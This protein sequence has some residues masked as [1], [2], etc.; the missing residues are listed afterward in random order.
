MVRPAL[1]RGRKLSSVQLS[2]KLMWYGVATQRAT[3]NVHRNVSQTNCLL[4]CLKHSK[5]AT[6][7]T[8]TTTRKKNSD[9]NRME[10]CF[11]LDLF[12][13]K[14]YAHQ[15][16]AQIRS[17]CGFLIVITTLA[18][19]VNHIENKR[20]GNVVGT[21][22]FWLK[23]HRALSFLRGNVDPA[24]I[25]FNP[26]KTNYCQPVQHTCDVTWNWFPTTNW[27]R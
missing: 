3:L 12:S 19:L 9:G 11:T 13:V 6:K 21:F 24:S 8:T 23:H 25:Q 22:Q 17:I 14:K 15:F 18:R 10:M 1:G 7:T 27:C 2:P 4:S 5:R 20:E 16:T 26:N